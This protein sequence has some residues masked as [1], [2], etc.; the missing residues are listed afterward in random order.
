MSSGF[1]HH[2]R[3]DGERGE[4]HPLYSTCVLLL[5]LNYNPLGL[6]SLFI[7]L[8]AYMKMMSLNKT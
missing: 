6:L 8:K 4:G 1:A 7:Q 3:G 2:C 5:N